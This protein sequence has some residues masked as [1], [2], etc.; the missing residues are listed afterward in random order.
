M[1]GSYYSTLTDAA[2]KLCSHC[3]QSFP[4]TAAALGYPA[5]PSRR[6]FSED[7]EE[8]ADEQPAAPRRFE[9]PSETEGWTIEE[10]AQRDAAYA[11]LT[12][13]AKSE[14][15]RDDLLFL[16]LIRG[17]RRA[18]AE[19]HRSIIEEVT[20]LRRRYRTTPEP[21]LGGSLSPSDFHRAIWP[22]ELVGR[23]AWGHLIVVERVR[24]VDFGRLLAMP[25]DAVLRLRVQAL[26]ALQKLS[27]GPRT[28]GTHRVYKCVFICDCR[29]ASY[30]SLAR[31]ETVSLASAYARL[32]ERMYA[33]AVWRNVV[34]DAPLVARAAWRV[35]E[36]MLGEE[37]R[38]L[39]QF[40]DGSDPQAL[41]A[42][43]VPRRCCPRSTSGVALADVIEKGDAAA[44]VALDA[45]D[46]RAAPSI[47][48][49][50]PT[51]FRW[52]PIQLF[53]LLLL[54][55]DLYLVGRRRSVEVI[56]AEVLV[57]VVSGSSEL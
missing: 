50:P 28:R 31:K 27:A 48:P 34:V 16:R 55:L 40:L 36:P 52:W 41:E 53:L 8:D 14:L 21:P 26:D 23:D 33:D 49:P 12:D 42:V 39:M 24:D 2:G 32:T 30:T 10:I 18:D 5:R 51:P 1:S 6:S 22:T 13:T 56:G 7:N 11:L 37:T 15:E 43:G 46:L 9:R 29:H 35:V 38:W 54:A 47:P 57:E 17:F 19:R 4:A 44:L 3:E 20:T 25:I 45:M